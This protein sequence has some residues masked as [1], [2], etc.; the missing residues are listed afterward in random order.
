MQSQAEIKR[1]RS[2]FRLWIT[3]EV[4]AILK[5]PS[6]SNLNTWSFAV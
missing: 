4:E 1:Y 5:V 3:Q 6:S 2:D